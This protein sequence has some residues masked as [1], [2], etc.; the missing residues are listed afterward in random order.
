M[1]KMDNSII[2]CKAADDPAWQKYFPNY[3]VL[4]PASEEKVMGGYY[5]LI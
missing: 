5:R 1:M 3:E 2:F 4:T